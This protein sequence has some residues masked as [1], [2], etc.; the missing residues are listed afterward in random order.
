MKTE[1]FDYYLPE[2]RIAAYPLENRAD[3]KLLVIYRKSQHL[4]HLHFRDFPQLINQSWALIRNDARVFKARLYGER[5]TGG[6]AECLLLNPQDFAD[7]HTWWCL[8][9]PGRK[10]KPGSTL[11]IAEGFYGEILQR[12]NEGQFLIHWN[13]DD[14]NSSVQDY[15]D[16]YGDIP[17]PHYITGQREESSRFDDSN[18]YQTVFSNNKNKV[19]AAAPT[20][21]LH[22]TPEIISQLKN[23]GVD[24]Y[25]LTLHIGL[26]TFKPIQTKNIEDH[27]IHTEFYTI[28]SRLIEELKKPK[29]KHLAIGTTSTRAV[30]HA[31]RS[32][33]FYSHDHNH[34][35]ED[36]ADI[37]IYPPSSFLGLDAML[38]NFHLPQ[39]TLLCL[40]SA[41]LTPGSADGI[42]WL[43]EIYKE[44][45]SKK[46]R[47][48]SYGDAMII[49]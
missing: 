43:K 21:G 29:K 25:D 48:Y 10:F 11:K 44:A 26:G 1:L 18:S 17:L 28:P 9:K 39:S 33:R 24:I 37:Y 30:E 41:F 49:L 40:V 34:G 31:M 8:L 19:A 12:N 3:S 5:E 35:F 27:P 36:F 38:T 15:A 32:K 45:I 47:F 13:L 2:D 23:Q 46:Y 14:P 7:P 42:A 16:Q 20:A 4:Q 22:F 6:K